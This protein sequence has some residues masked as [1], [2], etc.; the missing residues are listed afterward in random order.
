ML[1]LRVQPVLLDV[2]RD[3]SLRSDEAF[4]IAAVLFAIPVIELELINEL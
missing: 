1:R 2:F 3:F 4:M